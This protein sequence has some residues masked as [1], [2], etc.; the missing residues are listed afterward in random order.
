[1][2]SLAG[3]AL[4]V[5]GR[6]PV[7]M[8]VSDSNIFMPQSALPGATIPVPSGDPNTCFGAQNQAT[9]TS[10]PFCTSQSDNTVHTLSNL[11]TLDIDTLRECL[12]DSFTLRGQPGLVDFSSLNIAGRPQ[13]KH[14]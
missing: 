5:S 3:A 14:T 11:T 8:P 1:M 13:V 7:A 10:G 12:G 2:N 6:E 9:S 4:A